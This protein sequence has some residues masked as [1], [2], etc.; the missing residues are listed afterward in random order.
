M[1]RHKMEPVCVTCKITDTRVLIVHH[2]DHDRTNNTISNLRWLC[3][4]CHYLIH[5]GKTF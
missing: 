4:N 1:K 2:L 5:E 3:R